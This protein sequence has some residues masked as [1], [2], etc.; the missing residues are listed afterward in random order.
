MRVYTF[1]CRTSNAPRR[2]TGSRPLGSSATQRTTKNTHYHAFS[3]AIFSPSRQTSFRTPRTNIL[4]RTSTL[5]QKSKPTRREHPAKEQRKVAIYLRNGA[6]AV[7]S[8]RTT[9]SRRR[10][11]DTSAAVAA[12]HRLLSTPVRATFSSSVRSKMACWRTVARICGERKGEGGER[13]A[14]VFCSRVDPVV[15]IW[16]RAVQYC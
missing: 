10:T 8:N 11:G 13:C 3:L 16:V 2:Y 14:F 4:R 1:K 5:A 7:P 9:S 12:K 15:G 6:P